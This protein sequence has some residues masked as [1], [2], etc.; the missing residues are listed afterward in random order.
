TFL[1]GDGFDEVRGIAVD[2]AGNTYVTGRTSS[3][4]FPVTG[5]VYQRNIASTN[6]Y[7]AFATIIKPDGTG[8]VASSYIGGTGDEVGYALKLGPGGQVIVA[9]STY[10]TNLPLSS[11]FDASADGGQDCFLSVFNPTLT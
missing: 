2:A 4:N 9:G 1:G 5:G 6:I 8:L 10:S 3:S 7:D 11:A